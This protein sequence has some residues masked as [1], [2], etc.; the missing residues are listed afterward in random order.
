MNQTL[1]VL[2]PQ[3][4]WWERL[5]LV[6]HHGTEEHDI[7]QRLT[8]VQDTLPKIYKQLSILPCTLI[9]PSSL[10]LSLSSLSISSSPSD[11]LSH[12]HK[13]HNHHHNRKL[14]QEI[15]TSIQ[16]QI[17]RILYQQVCMHQLDH[18]WWHGS[19]AVDEDSNSSSSEDDLNQNIVSFVGNKKSIS[20]ND[21]SQPQHYNNSINNNINNND[22]HHHHHHLTSP[23]VMSQK[24]PPNSPI[25]S[26]SFPASNGS[27]YSHYSQSQLKHRFS[28]HWKD[29]SN[30][31]TPTLFSSSSPPP[32]PVSK[33]PF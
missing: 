30:P 28:K 19:I 10:S 26:S 27:V 14:S 21:E 32:I 20:K 1:T 24:L 16:Q 33:F 29:R 23:P 18:G 17:N 9:I 8:L 15:P 7:Y 13:Y 4:T 12:H 2:D 3:A 25:P 31:H 11:H 5:V 22:H 6:F